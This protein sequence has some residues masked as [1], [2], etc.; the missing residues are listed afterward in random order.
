MVRPED[1]QAERDDQVIVGGLGERLVGVAAGQ[2]PF[3]RCANIDGASRLIRWPPST[4]SS[5][6]RSAE[7]RLASAR[8]INRM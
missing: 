7:H 5:S 1:G 3:M 8:V 2:P 6:E 4:G